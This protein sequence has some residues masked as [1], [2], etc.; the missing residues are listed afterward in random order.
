MMETCTISI[1]MQPVLAVLEACSDRLAA[2]DRDG[3][4]TQELVDEVQEAVLAAVAQWPEYQWPCG[5]CG[6]KPCNPHGHWPVPA[7]EL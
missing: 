2:A 5:I 6:Q 4:A 1:D 7:R 3:T